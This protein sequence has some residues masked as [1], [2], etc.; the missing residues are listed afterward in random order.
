MANSTNRAANDQPSEDT[1]EPTKNELGPEDFYYEGPYLVFTAAYHLKRGY[2]C[3]S[4]CR[5]CP[6]K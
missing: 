4:D 1:F 2:C 5:H 3:N 6:Y